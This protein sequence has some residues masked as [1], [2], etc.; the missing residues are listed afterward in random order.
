M[1]PD[2][3]AP[4]NVPDDFEFFEV[5]N[6]TGEAVDLAARQIGVGYSTDAA[7]TDASFGSA[8]KFAVSDGV[9]GNAV[10]PG[11]LAAVVPAH[12]STVFWLDYSDG[13]VNT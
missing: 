2:N 12:G 8:L 10:T 9:A 6:T 5:T 13:G 3:G 7:P 4:A 11:P 1:H